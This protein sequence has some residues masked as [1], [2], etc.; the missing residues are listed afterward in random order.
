MRNH[1]LR[2]VLQIERDV[3]PCGVDHQLELVCR[4]RL[5]VGGMK[6]RKLQPPDQDAK[7]LQRWKSRSMPKRMEMVFWNLF[8][9]NTIL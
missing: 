7:P 3:V 8:D 5:S 2:K 6:L 4:R 1:R 9:S